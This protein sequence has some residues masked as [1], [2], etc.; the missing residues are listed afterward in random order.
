MCAA[1]GLVGKG[2][3]GGAG[4]GWLVRSMTYS[5]VVTISRGAR[6]GPVAW[7][8]HTEV[9]LLHIVQALVSRSCYHVKSSTV[10]DAKLSSSV[11][12]RFGMG[13]MAPLGRSR[14][15]RYMFSGEVKMWRSI[16]TGRITMKRK[17]LP[18][19]AIHHAWWKIGRATCRERVCQYG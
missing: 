11:S 18:T 8:G 10:E 1:G 3:W 7:A 14:S 6:C 15:F 9:R 2:W 4:D 13:F 12:I 19:W 17:K 5:D 16:V